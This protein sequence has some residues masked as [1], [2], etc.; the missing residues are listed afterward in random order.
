[1]KEKKI[2]STKPRSEIIADNIFYYLDKKNIKQKDLADECLVNS[3]DVSKWKKYKTKVNIDDL[4][5]IASFLGVSVKDLYYSAEEK[6]NKIPELSDKVD[7]ST[8]LAQ[9]LVSINIGPQNEKSFLY[10][11]FIILLLFGFVFLYSYL[12][13]DSFEIISL[14]GIIISIISIY[15]INYIDT[16]QETFVLNYMSDAC[17][18]IENKKNQY[19]VL[20]LV[21]KILTVLYSTALTLQIGYY[22]FTAYDGFLL[23]LFIP[24]CIY[25]IVT[26]INLCGIRR[27]YKEEIYDHEFNFF[28][29]RL[30]SLLMSSVLLFI[31]I[32]FIIFYFELIIFSIITIFNF[33]LEI[34]Q[35]IIG[36]I[37]SN[38]YE[39]A[40]IDENKKVSYLNNRN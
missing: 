9:R 33:V 24:L 17:Y 40:V 31:S 38:E 23:S 12:Y 30:F 34:I 16:R 15:I 11:P 2:L 8:I 21:I 35:Y 4:E 32:F 7:P 22:L 26:I 18:K 5:K 28:K 36:G 27:N 19:Y 25:F 6:R 1:M 10:T 29:I 20:D 3:S 14:L 37:K 39:M 13:Y